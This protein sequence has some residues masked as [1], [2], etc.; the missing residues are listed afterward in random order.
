MKSDWERCSQDALCEARTRKANLRLCL[1]GAR[2]GNGQAAAGITLLA[3]YPCGRRDLIYRSGR[4][5]G[6]LSSAFAS[7]MLALDVAI[8]ALLF[9]MDL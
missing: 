9:L 2:R 7:E 4:L 1:D 6:T 3:Y 8:Q 5:L